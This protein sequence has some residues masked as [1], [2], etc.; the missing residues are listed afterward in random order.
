MRSGLNEGDTLLELLLLAYPVLMMRLRMVVCGGGGGTS[1]N[2]C[3]L[4]VKRWF[5][6]WLKVFMI[7]N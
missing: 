3:E 5:I 4:K 2:C 1:S 7:I 6:G